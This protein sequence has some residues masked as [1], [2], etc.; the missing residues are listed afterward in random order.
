ML[1][2]RWTALLG[3]ALGVLL[4]LAFATGTSRAQNP[5]APPAPMAESPLMN[6]QMH[7]MMDIMRGDGTSQR[8]HEAL[9][10]DAGGMVEQCMAMMQSMG[11]DM[12]AMMQQM[13]GMMGGMTAPALVQ[14]QVQEVMDGI[15]GAGFA[16]QMQAA[17]SNAGGLMEQCAAMMAMMGTMPGMEA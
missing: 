8:E 11:M 17:M 9:G 10:N 12:A 14:E 7:Q 15:M 6:E 13:G 4:V 3:G 1:K 2:R 16:E 5:P